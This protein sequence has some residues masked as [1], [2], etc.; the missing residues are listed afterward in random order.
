MLWKVIVLVESLN[1]TYITSRCA[2]KLNHRATEDTEKNIVVNL[3]TLAFLASL[4][5]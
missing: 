3:K 1:P 4:A 5:V 2:N